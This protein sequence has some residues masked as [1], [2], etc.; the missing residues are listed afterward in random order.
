MRGF[1]R[2]QSPA[3]EFCFVGNGSTRPS[4]NVKFVEDAK[5]GFVAREPE[6]VVEII[7]RLQNPAELNAVL[8][9]VKKTRKP[10]AAID[11]ADC[12]LKYL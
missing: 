6:K 7:K 4:G 8:R 5:V 11:I 10:N 1:L 12:I 9:N 2:S 3:G